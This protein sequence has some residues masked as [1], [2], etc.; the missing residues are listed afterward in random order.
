MRTFVRLFLV[1]SMPLLA[2]NAMAHEHT[3]KTSTKASA[4]MQIKHIMASDSSMPMKST[5]NVDAGF[6]AMMIMHHHQA[7]KMSEVEMAQG[8]NADLKAVAQTMKT[9]QQQEISKLQPFTKHP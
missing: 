4:S 1:T 9:Q 5:G 6:A 2:C 7:I 8:K 3:S